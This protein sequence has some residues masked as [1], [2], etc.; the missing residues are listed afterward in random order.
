MRASSDYL[1]WRSNRGWPPTV[2]LQEFLAKK[3]NSS[4]SYRRAEVTFF[5]VPILLY[6]VVIAN[7][8][9]PGVNVLNSKLAFNRVQAVCGRR[10]C[11]ITARDNEQDAIAPAPKSA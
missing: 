1:L 3:P 11:R 9:V 7:P 4:P 10:N 2:P 6:S 8:P 5:G